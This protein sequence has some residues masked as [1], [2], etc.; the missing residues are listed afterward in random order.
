MERNDALTLVSG[1]TSGIG[2]ALVRRLAGT[3]RLLLHG[4][5]ETALR[6][7]RASLPD[8]SAHEIWVQD[9]ADPGAVGSALEALLAEKGWAVS[10]FVHVAGVF[11]VWQ[12][13]SLDMDA[14]RRMFDVNVFSAIEISRQLTRKRVNQG[15]LTNILFVSSIASRIG[16]KGY[17]AYAASKGALNALARS[18]AV[19]LA[20]QVR[21]NCILP[22]G[23]ETKSTGLFFSTPEM[24]AK[25]VAGVPLGAGGVDDVAAM[26]E[27]LL[28]ADARWITGQEF[29]VDG[30]RSIV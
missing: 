3:R 5:D 14:V 15:A 4:R 6:E 21:V 2:S 13:R 20:P 18:L 27:F 19:E 11:A 29:V 25:T 23:V 16:L 8:A 30:G 24:A 10:A 12:T 26:A 1:A 17:Q 22:G 28:S 7:L 9:L